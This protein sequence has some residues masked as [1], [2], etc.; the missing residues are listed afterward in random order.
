MYTKPMLHNNKDFVSYFPHYCEDGYW[1]ELI[2][3]G[4]IILKLFQLISLQQVPTRHDT[5]LK[6]TEP[7][8]KHGLEPP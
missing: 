3:K 7:T 8:I 1:L 2:Q 5:V 4:D 6:I